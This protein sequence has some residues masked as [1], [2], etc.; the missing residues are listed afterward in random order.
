MKYSTQQLKEHASLIAAQSKNS[1]TKFEL[2]VEQGVWRDITNP[3][4][5]PGLKYRIKQPHIFTNILKEKFTQEDIDSN[6]KVYFYSIH[7]KKLVEYE[8]SE[9]KHT[10]S[11]KR[12]LV[13]KTHEGALKLAIKQMK[14]ISKNNK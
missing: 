2:E 14:T 13:S 8:I 1:K 7:L 3:N 11:S 4:F 12:A 5:C 9:I 10:S 6:I